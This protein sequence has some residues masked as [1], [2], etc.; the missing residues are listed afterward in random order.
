MA[1]KTAAE[2]KEKI[3]VKFAEVFG[4]GEG[5]KAYFAPGRVNMIGERIITAAMCFHV[6]LP[7]EPMVRHGKGRIGNSAFIP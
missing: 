5:T 3:L 1:E 6:R 2:M 7:S 4:E